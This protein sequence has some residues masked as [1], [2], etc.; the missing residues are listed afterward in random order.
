MQEFVSPVKITLTLA[1]AD[2]RTEKQRDDD[3]LP[4]VELVELRLPGKAILEVLLG[5][6]LLSLDVCRTTTSQ[7]TTLEL[8]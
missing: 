6:E 7:L 1:R 4:T 3:L 2:G 8:M 5:G